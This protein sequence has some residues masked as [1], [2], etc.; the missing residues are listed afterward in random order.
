MPPNLHISLRLKIDH[1]IGQTW[2]DLHVRIFS[3]WSNCLSTEVPSSLFLLSFSPLKTIL[4]ALREGSLQWTTEKDPQMEPI[5]TSDNITQQPR[6]TIA[7]WKQEL[8]LSLD[9][10]QQILEFNKF[11]GLYAIVMACRS[12]KVHMITFAYIDCSPLLLD[13]GVVTCRAPG[14]EGVIFDAKVESASSLVNK[15]KAIQYEPLV[16][17]FHRFIFPSAY[18]FLILTS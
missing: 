7:T 8:P 1:T 2:E 13:G 12:K 3:R 5:P 10:E 11:P 6:I 16:I 9:N 14:R 4:Q 17:D 15:D 18:E